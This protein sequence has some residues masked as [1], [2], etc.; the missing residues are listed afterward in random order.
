MN[1][2]TNPAQPMPPVSTNSTGPMF[3]TFDP[4]GAP[5]RYFPNFNDVLANINPEWEELASISRSMIFR[6]TVRDNHPAGGCT[7]E[8]DVT[9]TTNASMGPFLVTSPNTNVTYPA[10][11]VQTVTWNVANTTAAPVSCANVDILISVDGGQTFSTLLANTPNDGSQSV[12]MPNVASNSCRILI[13][14]SNNYFYDVSNT[15]FQL[16]VLLPV[17]LLDFNATLHGADI[18]LDWSTASEKDNEGFRIERSTRQGL[19]FQEIGRVDALSNTSGIRHYTFTDP[20]PVQNGILYY[21]LKQIDNDGQVHISDI[22]V[23]HTNGPG[24]VSV[25]PNPANES[26]QVT[27]PENREKAGARIKIWNQKGELVTDQAFEPAIPID[28]QALANGVYSVEITMESALWHTT[29]IKNG[30]RR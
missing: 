5:S 16:Q 8:D 15:D 13:Q 7:A 1:S 14:C 10:G 2:Y 28:I 20:H 22:R 9:I 21:R 23:V 27:I 4:A 30:I 25:Y 24:I 18:V 11:S 29:F 26:I 6:V 17:T 19:D 12:T 3:R